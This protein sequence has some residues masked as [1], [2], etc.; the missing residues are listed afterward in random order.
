MIPLGGFAAPK[1]FFI[2]VKKVSGISRYMHKSNIF[3]DIS[4]LFY[5]NVLNDI[6]EDISTDV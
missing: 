1:N 2:A 6:D 3:P 5:K 4:H